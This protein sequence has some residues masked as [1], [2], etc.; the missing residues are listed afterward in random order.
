VGGL[1]EVEAVPA[2]SV[3]VLR[4]GSNQVPFEVLMIHRVEQ[5]SFVPN[6]WVFPGGMLETLDYEIG[7]GTPIGAMRVAGARELFEETGVWLGAPLDDAEHKRRQLLAGVIS[8]R[9][10]LQEADV[11]F[12]RLVWT[13]HWITPFGVPKRFDTWFFLAIAGPDTTATAQVTEAVDAVWI[14]P[15]EALERHR[16]GEWKMVFPT[17]RNLEAICGYSS[18]EELLEERRGATIEAIQPVIVDG[19]IQLP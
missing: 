15:E 3:L 9:Q 8:F 18:G 17:V 13:S 16:R 12:E 2:A 14:G 6:A 4:P 10:L 7:G 5:A 1:A 11:D 19:R